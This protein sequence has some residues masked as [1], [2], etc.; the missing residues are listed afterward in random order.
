M[1]IVSIDLKF[2]I[3]DRSRRRRRG[4]L[5]GPPDRGSE[6]S[7]AVTGRRGRGCDGARSRLWSSWSATEIRSTFTKARVRLQPA[8]LSLLAHFSCPNTYSYSPRR[9]L[10][11]S[12]LLIS[13][14]PHLAGHSFTSRDHTAAMTAPQSS[15]GIESAPPPAVSS[16]RSR[17]EKLAA[18]SS[19]SSHPSL[20]PSPAP[21]HSFLAPASTPSS[22]QL[23]PSPIPEH[24]RDVSEQHPHFLHPSSSSSDVRI[25]GKRPPPPP[26][27]PLCPPSRTPSPAPARSPLLRPVS[28][29]VTDLDVP[30]ESLTA[31]AK[32]AALARRPPPPPPPSQDHAAHRTAPVSSLVKQ[33]GCVFP[34]FDFVS[35]RPPFPIASRTFI[36]WSRTTVVSTELFPASPV[37]FS[38]RMVHGVDAL[39]SM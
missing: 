16:L 7:R 37:L 35:P 4:S 22:P 27:S 34:F 32:V 38:L 14:H 26:P 5:A 2:T 15:D 21:A 24:D 39:H 6:R 33:F 12:G 10:F 9:S 30:Q 31:A 3:T 25:V 13:I 1:V 8:L 36:R 17:F 18:D 29:A 11:C 28:P 19:V 23:R 20:K